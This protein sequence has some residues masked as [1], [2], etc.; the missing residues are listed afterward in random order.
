MS[1]SQWVSS[2]KTRIKTSE[3]HRS[4]K[5][6]RL[7]EYLPLKQGLRRRVPFIHVLFFRL[8]EYLPLKQGL[9]PR[10]KRKDRSPWRLPQ[11]VSSIKTRIKTNISSSA[12][13]SKYTQWVSSIKT[14]I[15]TQKTALQL[16]YWHSQWV[17]SIKTR[18]KTR[19]EFGAYGAYGISQWVSSIKT[20]IKTL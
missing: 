7:N 17:S 9:R 4:W 6:H 15:K 1:L 3:R 18:I 12:G 14:R 5:R 8:N 19:F 10:C 13:E 11:W 2:I 20:R 16:F